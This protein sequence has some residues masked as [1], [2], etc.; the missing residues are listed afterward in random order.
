MEPH[1]ACLQAPRLGNSL[2][3]QQPERIAARG[4][5][6]LVARLLWRLVERTLRGHVATPGP[7]VTGWAKKATPKPPACMLRPKGAAVLV[8]KV[9]AQ[10]PLAHPLAAVQQHSLLARGIPSTDLTT[11]QHG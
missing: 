11:P 4:L 3:L 7:P 5:G 9:G 10:R 2:G 1:G 8:L 6:G